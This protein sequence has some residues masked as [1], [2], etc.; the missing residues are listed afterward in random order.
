[1]MLPIRNFLLILLLFA[2]FLSACSRSN[3]PIYDR[4]G[5]GGRSGS[6]ASRISRPAFYKVKRGDTLYAIA[7]RFGMEF[8]DLAGWNSI[9]RPYTIFPGEKLRLYPPKR[10]LASTQTKPSVQKSN[11]RSSSSRPVASK[12]SVSKSPTVAVKPSSKPTNSRSNTP[13]PATTVATKPTKPKPTKPKPTPT[14]NKATSG[15]TWAWPAKGGILSTYS[16]SD[17]SRKGIDIAGKAGQEVLAAADGEVVYSGVGLIGYG[18]LI[19]IKH[20]QRYLSAY[21]HNRKRLVNEGERVKRGQRIAEMGQSGSN[22]IKLHFEIRD[23]G[24]PIDPMRFL[25]KR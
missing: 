10:P 6:S 7:W 20:S 2:M 13:K 25:P 5:H 18:E 23:N 21:G 3:A 17:A 16:S 15:T 9:G 8:R 19:I 22:R 1:M 24:V 14:P 4:S 11:T 12:P